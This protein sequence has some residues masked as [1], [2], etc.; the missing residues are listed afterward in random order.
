MKLIENEFGRKNTLVLLVPKGDVGKESELCEDLEKI[1]HVKSIVSYVTAIGGEIPT[2]YVPEDAISQFYSENYARLILYT[3]TEEEGEEAFGTV[4]SI[5]DTAEKYYNT[6][7]LS[8]QSAALYDMKNIVSVDTKLVN[9][10]AAIGIFIVLLL[11]FKS[12]TIP[13]FLLFSIETAI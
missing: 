9:I 1:P 12:L 6:C 5:F 7:F 8:G 2:E 3:D 10:M 11:T 4:E 13:L